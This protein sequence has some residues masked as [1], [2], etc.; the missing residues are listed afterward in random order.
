MPK[1]PILESLLHH[2]SEI[3]P[4]FLDEPMLK[5]AGRVDCA[6]VVNQL[7][8]RF[9]LLP[10]TIEEAGEI[11]LRRDATQRNRLRMI[12]VSSWVLSHVWFR[13]NLKSPE[14]IV[15]LLTTDLE[16]LVQSVDA[17]KCV[18][19]TD[20]REELVRF[21][22]MRLGIRPEGETEAYAKDRLTTLSTAERQRVLK[23]SRASEERAKA[24]R[25]ALKKK[26]AQES[27]DKWTRD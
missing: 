15:M 6:G 26:V 27:A 9:G 4:E 17:Q 24:L 19:E 5:N 13:E 2:L 14:R 7:L 18:L 16:E 20:R 10:L 12:L 23:A 22:L 25:D 21:L 11:N 8:S 3:P 1:G